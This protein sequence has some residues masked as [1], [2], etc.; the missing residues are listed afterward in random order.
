MKKKCNFISG[1]R[2]YHHHKDKAEYIT[3][4]FLS[5]PKHITYIFYLT[6]ALCH[7]TIKS[8]KIQSNY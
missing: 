3:C 5:E 8:F 2:C 4:P 6:A 7:N 1:F